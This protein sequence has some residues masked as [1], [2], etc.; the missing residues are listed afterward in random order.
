MPQDVRAAGLLGF[1]STAPQP[2]LP[3]AAADGHVLCAA[4]PFSA[5]VRRDRPS[6]SYT[7]SYA[8]SSLLHSGAFGGQSVLSVPPGAAPGPRVR[9]L[10]APQVF[11]CVF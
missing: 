2:P 1:A 4:S 5:G 8:Q 7:G 3:Q 9:G 6:C 11:N 10:C